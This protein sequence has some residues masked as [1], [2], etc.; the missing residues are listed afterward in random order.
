MG[1]F[2]VGEIIN[3][4]VCADDPFKHFNIFTTRQYIAFPAFLGVKQ[5]VFGEHFLT[6]SHVGTKRQFI[7]YGQ[8]T[9]PTGVRFYGKKAIKNLSQPSGRRSFPFWGDIATAG[10]TLITIHILLYLRQPISF[11]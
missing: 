9:R 10:I 8:M 11:G 4:M 1:H 3:G 6:E 2:D 7:A 5:A